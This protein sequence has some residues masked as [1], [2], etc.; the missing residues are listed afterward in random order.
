MRDD[1]DCRRVYVCEPAGFTPGFMNRLARESGAYAAVDRTGLQINMNGD[2]VSVHCLRTGK[3]DFTLPHEAEVTN[4][5]TGRNLG[6][7][8]SIPLN[9]TGGETRWYGINPNKKGTTR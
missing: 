6:T 8:R 5:K 2:F 1:P 4:L 7:M 9:M 3:Y